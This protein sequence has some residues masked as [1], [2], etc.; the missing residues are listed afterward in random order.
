VS[1]LTLPP[2]VNLGLLLRICSC[3]PSLRRRTSP[4]LP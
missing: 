1:P 3:A 2:L 4:K